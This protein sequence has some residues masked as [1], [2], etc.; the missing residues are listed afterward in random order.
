MFI[1]LF[2]LI[3][4]DIESKSMNLMELAFNIETKD[5]KFND[6]IGKKAMSFSEQIDDIL[7]K[8]QEDSLHQ[9][10]SLFLPPVSIKL[11][12]L[13]NAILKWI[14]S[15][16]IIKP[17]TK[18]PDIIYKCVLNKCGFGCILRNE[19]LMCSKTALKDGIIFELINFENTLIGEK[20]GRWNR[21]FLPLSN[22][23]NESMKSR[24]KNITK[25]KIPNT[26]KIGHW[27]P[28][29]FEYKLKELHVDPVL[30]FHGILTKYFLRLLPKPVQLY[31]EL[32]LDLKYKR[33]LHP[34]LPV[35]GLHIRRGDKYLE[36]NLYPLTVYLKI[37]KYYLRQIN[38]Q[39]A[40]IILATDDKI[41]V[42]NM[43]TY[44][45]FTNPY[46]IHIV[47]A[48]NVTISQRKSDN[49]LISI[50][51]DMLLLAESD[52]F[53]GQDSSNVASVVVQLMATRF[54]NHKI[55]TVSVDNIFA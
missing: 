37:I 21:M 3:P 41:V 39:D 42:E 36:A 6:I 34:Y 30:F 7:T 26:A 11:Q 33:R 17:D 24:C 15:N 45:L 53:V 31:D 48:N 40:I 25:Y 22:F 2:Y 38:S 1:Q 52:F 23:N 9:H 5:D 20:Y 4:N 16:Q 18:C 46:S 35:I 8:I 43:V 50:V 12:E 49:A 47:N 19:L 55:R 28:L 10:S 13:Q 14:E 51:F 54:S 29:K 27:I 44:K 32:L